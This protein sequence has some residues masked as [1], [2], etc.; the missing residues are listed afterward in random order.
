MAVSTPQAEP[1]LATW[2]QVSGMSI[3]A[4]TASLRPSVYSTFSAAAVKTNLI[5]GRFIRAIRANATPLQVC[6]VVRDGEETEELETE[7]IKRA[8]AELGNRGGKAR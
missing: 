3:G 5:A 1:T 7:R 8:A 4:A 2:R 6:G